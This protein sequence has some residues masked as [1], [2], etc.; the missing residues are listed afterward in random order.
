M[1]HTRSV[2]FV[3]HG[4]RDAVRTTREMQQSRCSDK[5][6]SSEKEDDKPNDLKSPG[7]HEP[8]RPSLTH[9]A[10]FPEH[11]SME[12]LALRKYLLTA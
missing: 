7:P 10:R 11:V 1:T 4:H 2:S 12:A 9:R 5:P 6:A 3:V 8:P